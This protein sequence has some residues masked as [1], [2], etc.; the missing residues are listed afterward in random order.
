MKALAWKRRQSENVLKL[1]GV[2]QHQGAAL[3]VSV[4]TEQRANAFVALAGF[5]NASILIGMVCCVSRWSSI[6]VGTLRRLRRLRLDGL[7]SFNLIVGPNN[8]G[9]TSLL[10]AVRLLCNPLDPWTW[11]DTSR[12]REIKSGRVSLLD[13]LRYVFPQS[14][15]Q[16]GSEPF[17]SEVCLA[18][19]GE[20]G[21]RVVHARLREFRYEPPESMEN[22]ARLMLFDVEPERD[23]RRG[24]VH[25][26][27]KSPEGEGQVEFEV[28][29]I[30]EFAPPESPESPPSIRTRYLSPVHHRVD[31]GT[32]RTLS[33]LLEG[34]MK[35]VLIQQLQRIDPTIAD[36]LV[37]VREGRGP[38][39]RV[40]RRE[41]GGVPLSNEGDGVRR[42]M[43]LAAEAFA[44][45]FDFSRPPGVLLVDEI[46]TALHPS[47]MEQALKAL[48]AASVVSAIGRPGLQIFATTHSLEA[49]DAV[50][51]VW[52]PTSGTALG[53]Q[54]PA[55]VAFY[56]LPP[57]GSNAPVVRYSW[58]EFRDRREEAGVDLR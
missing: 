35:A 45:V 53:S 4:C 38:E 20:L 46:E 44:L 51:R 6:E 43:A 3:R 30:K 54:G 36:V 8:S 22:A 56:R 19:E 37:V 58:E 21:R 32:L 39:I 55:G 52:D 27:V 41:G 24:V 13:S 7:Q 12:S 10:E 11:V 23:F 18:G 33:D 5:L 28:D 34:H 40:L 15:V 49:M 50:A 57:A 9:K 25:V 26:E 14:R 2:L 29:R 31:H 16:G 17:E 1:T 47:A 42:T 48:H